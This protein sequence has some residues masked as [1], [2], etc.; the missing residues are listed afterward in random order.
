LSKNYLLA[1]ILK[2]YEKFLKVACCVS[3]SID[4]KYARIAR[5][6]DI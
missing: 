5:L 6:P 4:K 3:N 2:K 1:A